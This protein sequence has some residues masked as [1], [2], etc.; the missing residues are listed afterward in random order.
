MVMA[1]STTFPNFSQIWAFGVITWRSIFMIVLHFFY[2][3]RRRIAAWHTRTVR[4]KSVRLKRD[5]TSLQ[6][7]NRSTMKIKH[8]PPIFPNIE[9][10]HFPYIYFM[11]FFFYHYSLVMLLVISLFIIFLLNSFKW[12]FFIFS[13]SLLFHMLG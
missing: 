7:K 3:S 12:I 5:S 4:N 13:C 10:V 6:K 1:S 8:N 11:N 2:S 9:P